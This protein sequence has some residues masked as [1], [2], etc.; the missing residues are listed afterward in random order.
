M[1]IS[2]VPLPIGMTSPPS[3]V[4]APYDWS[5]SPYQIFVLSLKLGWNL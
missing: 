4:D 1:P 2:T 5:E 3:S